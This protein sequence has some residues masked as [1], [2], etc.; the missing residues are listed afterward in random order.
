[1]I[2]GTPADSVEA[3]SSYSFQPRATDAEGDELSFSISNQPGWAGFD[4]RTGRLSGTPDNGDAGT[5]SDIVIAVSDG[6]ETVS[7]PAFSIRVEASTSGTGSLTFNWSAP[8]ARTD[9]TPLALTDID[10]YVIYFEL[11][12]GDYS[13]TVT[14][15]DGTAQT[16]TVT[17]VPIG[18]YY[19]VMKA[20]DNNG[21]ESA[22]SAEKTITSR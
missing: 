20:Y 3:N 22:F 18:N 7:L 4:N 8:V 10:G 5:Y 17:D 13:D 1:V 15:E 2:S 14:V 16:V 19:V 21:L 9:G 6:T 12:S 11:S